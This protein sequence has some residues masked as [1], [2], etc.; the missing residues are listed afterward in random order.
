MNKKSRLRHK[1][2]E[3]MAI[4]Q[5]LRCKKASVVAGLSISLLTFSSVEALNIGEARP[6]SYLG[7][8]LSIFVPVTD[9]SEVVDLNKLI[10]SKPTENQLTELNIT[11]SQNELSY[12][13]VSSGDAK[14]ILITSVAPFNEPFINLGVKV[15]YQGI[16]QLHKLTALI[17]LHPPIGIGAEPTVIAGT[18]LVTEDESISTTLLNPVPLNSV[19][20]SLNSTRSTNIKTNNNIDSNTGIITYNSDIMGPYDWA[21][22]GAIPEK[23]GPVLEGQ[24]L[25]RVARRINESMNVSIDQMMWALFRANPNAFVG[26]DVSTLQSGSIL[27]IPKESFVREVTELGAVR[28]LNPAFTIESAEESTKE[29]IEETTVESV[30]VVVE[31][32]VSVDKIINEQQAGQQSLVTPLAEESSTEIARV[33]SDNIE[34]SNVVSLSQLNAVDELKNE[35]TYLNEKLAAQETRI[36]VLEDRLAISESLNNAAVASDQTLIDQALTSNTGTIETTVVAPAVNTN[37]SSLNNNVI[38]NN[39][40][41]DSN[42]DTNI[43]NNN[44]QIEGRVVETIE[45]AQTT[46]EPEK[47][48][49]VISSKT[50]ITTFTEAFTEKTGLSSITPLLLSILGLFLLGLAYISRHR[51]IPAAL[52][53]FGSRYEYDKDAPVFDS[54]SKKRTLRRDLSHLETTEKSN[55]SPNDMDLTKKKEVEDFE[56]YSFFVDDEELMDVEELSF[57][58]RIKQ[59]IDSGDYDEARKTVS[60]ASVANINE[61]EIDV[62]MLK[63]FAAESDRESF[64]DLFEKIHANIDEY[65][66]ET[67]L[68]IAELQSEMTVGKMINFSTDQIAS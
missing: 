1:P 39:S 25:W 29:N 32:T 5:L 51:F 3:K 2:I 31:E 22:A 49:E 48:A 24:S 58:D 13:I 42:S 54:I 43:I 56:D 61:N 16:S 7:Q 47:P 44:E 41:N 53:L 40:L 21:Q 11:N 6:Q 57:P 65:D 45:T 60:F 26:N 36:K 17:D 9:I 66:A 38:N 28:L 55:D 8:P 46:A 18:P 4:N 19:G 14:G 67:Q 37:D 27:S 12:K 34:G 63:I 62:Y 23:F 20:T 35:I 10:V 15:D 30:E 64:D 68:M 50:T 52:K 33:E 59:L